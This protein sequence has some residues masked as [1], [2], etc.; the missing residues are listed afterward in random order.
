MYDPDI[1][2]GQCRTLSVGR[3]PRHTA[4]QLVGALMTVILVLASTP[5]WS[6]IGLRDLDEIDRDLDRLTTEVVDGK[7]MAE[8]A[9]ELAS[10]MGEVYAV[11]SQSRGGATRAPADGCSSRLDDDCVAVRISKLTAAL[12]RTDAANAAAIFAKVLSGLPP[13]WISRDTAGDQA[14]LYEL[15]VSDREL[16]DR[17]RPVFDQALMN[18]SGLFYD[19]FYSRGRSDDYIDQKVEITDTVIEQYPDSRFVLYALLLKARLLQEKALIGYFSAEPDGQE[20][21]VWPLGDQAKQDL[22]ASNAV[23]E[24][25]YRQIDTVDDERWPRFRSDVLFFMALNFVLLDDMD[26]ANAMLNEMI[27]VN[28]APAQLEQVYI[29]KFLPVYFCDPRREVLPEYHVQIDQYFNPIQLANFVLELIACRDDVEMASVLLGLNRFQ[30]PDYRIFLGSFSQKMQAD[31]GKFLAE[32]KATTVD[33]ADNKARIDDVLSAG[34]NVACGGATS[35]VLP[36]APGMTEPAG[37]AWIGVYYGDGLTHK[38]GLEMIRLFRDIG[39]PGYR[40]A[41]LW[42]P[43]VN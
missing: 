25:I 13:G 14:Y 42:R 26:Q 22:A 10:L 4:P 9:T 31:A 24:T 37:D 15:I 21:P 18:S 28:R 32:V 27:K 1:T 19:A 35:V 38:Q 5:A 43:Q 23:Y 33:N 17:T 16:N 34:G 3:R 2:S 40:D 20:A 6:A 36:N 41:Y 7:G 8:H 11:C 39:V 12:R 30:N 29:N